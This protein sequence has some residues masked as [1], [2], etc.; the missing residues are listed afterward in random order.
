MPD[1]PDLRA[2][3]ARLRRDCPWDRAQD[4]ASMR[5][6]LLEECHEVLGALDEGD[7]AKLKEELGDLL[8]QVYFLARL[9][10]ERGEFSIEG[11]ESAIVDKMVS[12]HP[13]VFATE[14]QPEPGGI[15]AWERRKARAGRSRIDGVPVS[16]PALV[17][18]HRVA[19]KVAA[20]GFD[21]PDMR[22]VVDKIDEERRELAEA[23]A[24]GDSTR[25]A[26]EYGDLLLAAS[27][28]GRWVGVSGE[29]ALRMA[30]ARFE[31]RFRGV[32]ARAA[33]QGVDPAEAGME[34][35]EAWWQEA[36]REEE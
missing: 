5:P 32:E 9:A 31:R 25:V 8:F 3:V 30:N 23:L 34:R 35:L 29:D 19:E 16:L 17:R 6:Y 2:L 28:L 7:P 11:V 21:W 24:S 12:R 14:A 10:E 1:T 4:E 20:V 33:A 26:H 22:G 18:A 36:K 13:H 15:A 27:N